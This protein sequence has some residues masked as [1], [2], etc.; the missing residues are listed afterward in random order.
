MN[1]RSLR[2]FRWRDERSVFIALFLALIVFAGLLTYVALTPEQDEGFISMYV[3]DANR[4]AVNYPQV[5]VIGKNNTL[6]L[7]IGVE[8]LLGNTQY[9]SV[10]VKIYNGTVQTDPVP[11]NPLK[12]YEKVLVNREI[13]EFPATITLNQ[14]GRHKMIFELWLFDESRGLSYSGNSNNLWLDVIKS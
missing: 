14:T 3:L 12:S 4:M 13:W 6:W 8:N 1:L 2:N 5:L 7:S 10:L 9:C 11:V